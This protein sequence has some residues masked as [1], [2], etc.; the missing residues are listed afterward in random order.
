MFSCILE[1][2]MNVVDDREFEKPAQDLEVSTKD[3]LVQNPWAGSFMRFRSF[4]AVS[5]LKPT[6]LSHAS[7]QG[8][9]EAAGS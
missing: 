7:A 2:V 6:C 5:G 1:R 9:C 4:L 8:G 3:W